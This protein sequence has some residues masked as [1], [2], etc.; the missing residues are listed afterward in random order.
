[1]RKI[2]Y[3]ALLASLLLLLVSCETD[4]EV[5]SEWKEVTAVYGIVNQADSVH[6]IKI[7]KAFLGS[8]N[9]Y[10][11]ANTE[12]SSSYGGNLDVKLIENRNGSFRD[13][14]FDTV[15]VY[16]KD[17]VINNEPA[18]FY[19]RHQL[20]YKSKAQLFEDGIYELKIRNKVTGKEVSASTPLIHDFEVE[21]PLPNSTSFEFQRRITKEE[22][23]KWGSA[24][25]GICYQLTVRFYFKESSAPGDT[26]KRHVEWIQK[27]EKSEN[28]FG[29]ETMTSSYY[30]ETL[31]TTCV[32][33]IP[34]TDPAIEAEVDMRQVLYVDFIY[35]VIGNDMDTYMDFNGPSVGVFLDK[36]GYTNI[37][38]GI[39][40]F[41][42][43]F[44][45][46]V[47][48]KLGQFSEL[49]LIDIADLKFVKN[50]DN[51]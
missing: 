39:G 3:F 33:N 40:V 32:K 1:M 47:S 37:I 31:F 44:T 21:N 43:R 27:I 15:S 12:D 17:S 6:L 23:F 5:V 7:N 18:P 25:N 41:S 51:Y 34:Y 16:N 36:P 2:Q 50:P 10:L 8:G 30:N 29:G 20:L 42:C 49:D 13:I 22:K 4:F 19:F 35:A 26:V 38:N 45:K 11:Y 28:V 14:I 9:T 48:R 46:T 24:I